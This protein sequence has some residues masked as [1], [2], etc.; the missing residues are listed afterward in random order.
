VSRQRH[1][2]YFRDEIYYL[3][4]QASENMYQQLCG[5]ER[6]HCSGG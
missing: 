2:G 3:D 1:Y 6:N 4:M 5:A